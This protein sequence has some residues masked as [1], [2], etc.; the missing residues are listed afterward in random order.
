MSDEWN[1]SVFGKCNNQH[2]HGH[3]Y[4]VEVIVEGEVNPETGYLIDMKDLKSIL[5]HKV[6]AEVDHKHLNIEV[7]WLENTIPSAENLARVFFERVAK[8]LP[9]NVILAAIT[10]HETNQ[11]SATYCR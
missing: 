10:V 7:P 11:N 2:G 1:V 3:N 4:M 5:H 9:G 8:E 6:I